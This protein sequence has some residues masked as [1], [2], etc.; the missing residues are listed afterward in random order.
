MNGL[1]ISTVVCTYNRCG[2]L[3]CCLESLMRQT[4]PASVYEVIVVDNNSSDATRKVCE[5][6]QDRENFCY[7]FEEQ[8]G[9]SHAR[10]RG[11]RESR[12]PLVA[13]I[14]DDAVAV[15]GWLAGLLEGFADR[16]VATVG[17]PILPVFEGDRPAWLHDSLLPL[18]SCRDRG[19]EVFDLGPGLFFYGAN[20]SFRRDVLEQVAG[21]P[22]HLGR[23]G[24]N[25]LSDEELVV[26]QRIEALGYRMRY[27][28]EA[29]VH[30][31]IPRERLKM[32]WLLQRF[33]WLG[34]GEAL[35][36][37]AGLS[38]R[39][40]LYYARKLRYTLACMI[41]PEYSAGWATRMI[42]MVT[43]AGYSEEMLSNGK[44]E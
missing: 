44:R 21:F 25:L 10:N 31:S 33:Y 34:R 29:V 12:A 9:L 23:K 35:R 17:G 1:R 32:S 19:K 42:P 18:Y 14:D 40:W 22:E 39:C 7:F 20:M 11:L 8:Q 36:D 41:R 2:Y 13:Y 38:P 26:S 28:P 3:E 6:Y 4:L 27:L 30:H 5:C 37:G 16:R 15:S 24:D 43:L